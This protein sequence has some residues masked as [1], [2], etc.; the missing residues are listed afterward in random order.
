MRKTY[1]EKPVRLFFSSLAPEKPSK[2]V[3]SLS[4]PQNCLHLVFSSVFNTRAMRKGDITILE[5]F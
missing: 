1:P 2:P 5:S 3:I 4:A